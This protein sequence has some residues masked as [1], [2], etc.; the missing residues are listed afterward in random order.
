MKKDDPGRIWKHGLGDGG[1]NH[2]V[3][4]EKLTSVGDTIKP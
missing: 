2:G 3:Q 1:Q 4:Y